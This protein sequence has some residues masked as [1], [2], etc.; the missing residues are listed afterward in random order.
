MQKNNVFL[1]ISGLSCECTDQTLEAL[2]KAISGEEGTSPNIWA[3]HESPFIQSLIELFSSRGLLMIDKVNVELTAWI[4]GKR[5]AASGGGKHARPTGDTSRLNAH[6]LALV[7]IYL[8]NLPPGQMTMGDWGL[9]VDYLVSRHMPFDQLQTES[10]WMAV[11]STFMG[12]IQAS[13]A[14][15]T[16]AQADGLMAALPLTLAAVTTSFVPSTAFSNIIEYGTARCADNVTAVSDTMRHRIKRVVMAH[17]E[18]VLLGTR[19]PVQGL[20]SALFDEFAA[21]NRDWRR[22]A[23]TEAG[24]NANQGLIGSLKAGTRVRRVEQY[25]GSCPYCQK[26]NGMVY[27]VVDANKPNKNGETEVWVGKTNIGRSSAKRKRVD[28]ELVERGAEELWWCPAGTV[29]PHC[30]GIWIV[31]DDAQPGDDPKFATWLEAHFAKNRKTYGKAP[32]G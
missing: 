22:I 28:D 8:E 1:N 23:T 5:Y 17:Q 4:S 21:L 12:K 6:E 9:L 27:T 2:A 10:E 19:P 3:R 18:Q 24:E 20:Q 11:R 14:A 26:I 16:V 13:V 15:L 29:H 32:P 25:V 7:K 31:L 30:R